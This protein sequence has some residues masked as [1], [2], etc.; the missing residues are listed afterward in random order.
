MV[1]PQ[2]V[3]HG[4]GAFLGANQRGGLPSG[5]GARDFHLEPGDLSLWVS[6]APGVPTAAAQFGDVPHFLAV[7]AA[8]F[9]EI[10]ALAD[11]ARAR[12]VRTFRG[13]GHGNLP[14]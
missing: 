8:V 6:A 9:A 12:R 14:Q 5:S 4:K 2:G 11:H 13:V 10:S 7:L 1:K 3:C